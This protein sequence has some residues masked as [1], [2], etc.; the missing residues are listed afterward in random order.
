MKFGGKAGFHKGIFI[1]SDFLSYLLKII[2]NISMI[3][4]FRLLQKGKI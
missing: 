3:E 2:D 1:Y 4:R